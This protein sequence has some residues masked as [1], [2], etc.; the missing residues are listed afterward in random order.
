MLVFIVSLF[1]PALNREKCDLE[2]IG[3][4]CDDLKKGADYIENVLLK[5]DRTKGIAVFAKIKHQSDILFNRLITLAYSLATNAFPI[6][7]DQKV[8]LE[9][10]SFAKFLDFRGIE[11]E[12]IP[13]CE[14]LANLPNKTNF[15]VVNV[16]VSEMLFSPTL[17]KLY[18][19]IGPASLH[20]LIHLTLNLSYPLNFTTYSVFQG[21]KKPKNCGNYAGTEVQKNPDIYT[22]LN[23]ANASDIIHP[24]G[25]TYGW[26]I[27]LIR[28]IPPILYDNVGNACWK[29]NNYIAGGIN[30]IYPGTSR[31][32]NDFSRSNPECTNISLVKK[33]LKIL[34]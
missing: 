25:N 14:I 34:F 20:L 30:P 10:P 26:M 33:Y 6:F 29:A 16:S 11:G 31:S 24:I 21:P 3:F 28:G 7:D 19:A 22:I 27:N 5:R 15:Y 13:K 4:T 23:S 18:D 8:L 17:I 32:N 2:N 12:T 1:L 9:Y